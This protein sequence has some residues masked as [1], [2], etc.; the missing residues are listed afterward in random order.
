MLEIVFG[1]YNANDKHTQNHTPMYM[2]RSWSEGVLRV[3]GLPNF[4]NVKKKFKQA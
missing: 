3:T 4:E 1:H 2:A